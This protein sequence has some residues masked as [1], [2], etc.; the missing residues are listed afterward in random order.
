MNEFELIKELTRGANTDQNINPLDHG[1]VVG[2]GDDAAVV[3]PTPGMELV[4]SCDTLVEELHFHRW[5]LRYEDIGYKAIASNISDIAAMGGKPRW[6]LISVSRPQTVTDE[7]MIALYRGLYACAG[8]HGV[9][10]AGG[11]MT[12]SPKHLV[13]SVTMLGEVEQGQALVRSSA[14]P[15]DVVFVTGALGGSAAGLDYLLKQQRVNLSETEQPAMAAKLVQIHRRPEPHVLAGRLLAQSGKRAAL[16]DI[17]DGLASE[18]HEIAAASAC[19]I[20]LQE[21]LIPVLPEAKA[22]ANQS[23]G[24]LDDWVLFGGEEYVLLGTLSEAD[25]GPMQ[26]LFHEQGLQFVRIGSVSQDFQG[27]KLMKEQG[28]SCEL[29][30]GG[31]RHF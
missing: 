25:F 28:K 22:Y 7:Q 27:V 5:T 23:G 31:Y 6:A 2:V 3:Q 19:G 18:A 29:E 12:G 11:D 17:S 13:L 26:Q 15:G 21:E 16:N 24:P 4:M 30:P 20:L 9:V 8:Q 1:I 14:K 10:I